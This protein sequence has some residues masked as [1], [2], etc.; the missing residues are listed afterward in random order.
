MSARRNPPPPKKQVYPE[1][2]VWYRLDSEEEEAKRVL[3]E[4]ARILS[5]WDQEEARLLAY[6]DRVAD[7]WERAYRDELERARPSLAKLNAEAHDRM[8]QA[9]A[10]GQ[11]LQAAERTHTERT[12]QLERALQLAQNEEEKAKVRSLLFQHLITN[13][14]DFAAAPTVTDLQA[15]SRVQDS[16]AACNTPHCLSMEDVGDDQAGDQGRAEVRAAGSQQGTV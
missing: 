7:E 4:E 14:L 3:E 1:F 8:L 13:P 9:E 6:W 16:P 12:E 5:Y 10:Y 2:V 11:M 15:P